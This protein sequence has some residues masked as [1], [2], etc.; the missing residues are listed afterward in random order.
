MAQSVT[1]TAY[2]CQVRG[3]PSHLKPKQDCVFCVR[4]LVKVSAVGCILAAGCYSS[5]A[6]GNKWGREVHHGILLRLP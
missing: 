4:F 2:T 6:G 3:L 5:K 1:P